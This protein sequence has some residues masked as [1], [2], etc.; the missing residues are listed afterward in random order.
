[1]PARRRTRRGERRRRLGQNFLR[2]EV[3]ERLVRDADFV[4]GERVVE[5]GPGAGALTLA[6]AR[7]GVDL[8]AVE[9][10][11]AWADRLRSRLRAAGQ[12]GVR[13][14]AA[15][16]CA[17][18][19][20]DEPF[21]VVGS[22]PFGRT[23]AILAHLLD[24]PTRPL[25]RADLIVQWEVAR[26]RSVRPPSTLRSTAWA[27]WWQ[28]ELGP[29]IPARAFHPVPA[30]DAGVL[31]IRRRPEALLPPGMAGAWRAFVQRHWPFDRPLDRQRGGSLW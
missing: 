16:F 12:P 29:R 4:P 6:L 17:Y 1:M 26:K 22:L 8:V 14:V 18:R 2:A 21:R 5:V 7:R 9:L 19:L 28:L 30:V 13:V 24:D 31:R 3:A 20:P 15:D 25:R 27:P 23:S 11:R 10:D